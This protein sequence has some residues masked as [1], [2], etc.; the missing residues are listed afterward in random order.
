MEQNNCTESISKG[1]VDNPKEKG[2]N[3]KFLKHLQ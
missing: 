2:T 3:D 1:K